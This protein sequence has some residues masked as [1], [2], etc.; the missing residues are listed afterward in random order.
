VSAL[1]EAKLLD[2]RETCGARA[3]KFEEVARATQK[4]LDAQRLAMVELRKVKSEDAA[5]GVGL[6]ARMIESDQAIM[7]MFTHTARELREA[8][9][10][11]KGA[12]M[13]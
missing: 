8:L 10:S 5:A 1:D 11:T 12:V 3:A 2:L 6:L 13:I 4:R 7:L 9:A